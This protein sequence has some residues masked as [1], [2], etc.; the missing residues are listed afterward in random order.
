[1]SKTK[2]QRWKW[3]AL[4]FIVVAAIFV[5]LYMTGQ[6]EPARLRKIFVRPEMFGTAA[7]CMFLHYVISVQRWRILLKAQDMSLGFWVAMK[8]TF[9]GYY[10]STAIPGAVSGD[11]VKAYY[12]SKGKEQKAV[13][14][15]TVIF[16]RLLG[17]YTMVLV[18]AIAILFTML[19]AEVLGQPS[20]WSQQSVKT[21]GF[22]TYIFFIFLTLVGIIFT[23]KKL[24]ISQFIS[25]IL[26]KIPFH[27]T[28][29]K[30]YE[31]VHNY[32]QKR[33]FTLNALLLSLLSQFFLYTGIYFLCI[34]LNITTLTPLNYLF[35][36][37]VSL[38]INAIPLTPGGLGVGEAG[39]QGIFLLFGSDK[40]AEVAILFHAIFFI[41]AIGL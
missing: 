32:G 4:R 8:L 28:V 23:S 6:L 25:Y 2:T 30:A 11:I 19:Q 22:F 34:L 15:T 31:A 41:L 35:V 33:H 10:F 38:F 17:M 40:G 21:I 14:I 20:V 37:P 9:I 24:K 1:M 3:Y 26:I 12:V 18:A 27:K 16:D 13:L 39:F 5:F 36:L 7:I 29:I